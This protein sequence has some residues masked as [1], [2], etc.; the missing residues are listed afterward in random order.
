MKEVSS[1]CRVDPRLRNT[2]CEFYTNQTGTYSV[3]NPTGYILGSVLKANAIRH[4]SGSSDSHHAQYVA[5]MAD[6]AKNPGTA[7][8]PR[9]ARGGPKPS[10]CRVSAAR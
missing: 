1:S 4:E 7:A 2:N 3:G 6:P 10:S 5:A 8:E 9:V